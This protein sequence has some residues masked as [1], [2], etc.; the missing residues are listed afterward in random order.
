MAH[1]QELFPIMLVPIEVTSAVVL[2][3]KV[4]SGNS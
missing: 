1:F 3:L 4:T 2:S